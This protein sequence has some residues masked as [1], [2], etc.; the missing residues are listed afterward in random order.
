MTNP[1]GNALNFSAAV[2]LCG[3]KEDLA[4]EII[5]ML[6]NELPQQNLLL[7]TAFEQ[8]DWKQLDYLTHKL[9]GSAAYCG[10]EQIKTYA[11]AVNKTIRQQDLPQVI[12][13]L[14]MLQQAIT[15]ALAAAAALDIK[16]IE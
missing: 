4:R 11:H 14:P 2:Q 12:V 6:V 3:G 7:Q 16:P 8:H 15:A 9:S 5:P 10:M 1:E 13:Q